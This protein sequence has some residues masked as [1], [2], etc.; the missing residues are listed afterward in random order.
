MVWFSNLLKPAG[1]YTYHKVQH[2]KI[3]HWDHMECVIFMDLA[4]KTA[5]FA[6]QNVK[7]SAFL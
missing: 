6:L 5:N 7:R 4:K 2:S 1:N 3:L